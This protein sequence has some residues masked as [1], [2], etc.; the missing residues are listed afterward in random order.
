[1]LALPDAG[2]LNR[3]RSLQKDVEEA[4]GDHFGRPVPISLVVDGDRPPVP[5]DGPPALEDG[6]AG[7]PGPEGPEDDAVWEVDDLE[8]AGPAVISPEQR[9]LD[10]FPGAE[11]VTP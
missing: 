11:E 8:D 7:G 9:L 5:D 3:A 2:L 4:L 1:V 6:V 10:A